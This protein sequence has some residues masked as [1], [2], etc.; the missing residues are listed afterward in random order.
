MAGFTNSFMQMDGQSVSLTGATTNNLAITSSIVLVTPQA[1]G[2]VITG[3]IPPVE[4]A[5]IFYLVN[6]H[7]T[8]SVVLPYNSIHSTAGYRWLN[9]LGADMTVGAGETAFFAFIPGLGW[10]FIKPAVIP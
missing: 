3:A 1:D 5:G 8:R 9:V 7:A 4:Q 2:D 10:E 6:I